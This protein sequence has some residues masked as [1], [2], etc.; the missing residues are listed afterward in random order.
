MQRR[1]AVVGFGVAEQVAAAYWAR[2]GAKVTICDA[3]PVLEVP[4]PYAV[5]LGE[6]YLQHLGIVDLI[7]HTTAVPEAA[8]LT[9]N[10]RSPGLA[11][12]I[13]PT[14]YRE[15]AIESNHKE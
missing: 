8:I 11:G 2:R 7:V 12:R 10:P 15:P 1:V 9:A 4:E 13:V 14:S 6:L 5:Q 3:N